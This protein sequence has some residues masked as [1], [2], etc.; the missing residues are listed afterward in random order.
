MTAKLC[1]DAIICGQ[2]FTIFVDNS[3]NID[4][5]LS[6]RSEKDLSSLKTWRI[7]CNSMI[8]S[9]LLHNSTMLQRQ[10][11]LYSSMLMLHKVSC[12]CLCWD[13]I[14]YI[15][16]VREDGLRISNRLCSGWLGL[17]LISNS[18]HCRQK[19]LN[20]SRHNQMCKKLLITVNIRKNW[21]HWFKKCIMLDRR[22][23]L[24]KPCY[25]THEII[26]M[27]IVYRALDIQ[28]L[29]DDRN[30]LFPLRNMQLH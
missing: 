4:W 10:P 20:C 24:Q 1:N 15:M 5:I 29:R 6:L 30:K 22:I 16:D 21:S 12:I 8:T 9:S 2:Q 26:H 28:D 3:I 27:L 13:I 17:L 18:L 25:F 7:V 11:Q 23:C 14:Q 19:R